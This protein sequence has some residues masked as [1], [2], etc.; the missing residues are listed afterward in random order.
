MEIC[1]DYQIVKL[2]IQ[3]KI[4]AMKELLF[5]FKSSNASSTYFGEDDKKIFVVYHYDK[6]D[7]RR[8]MIGSMW[9][10]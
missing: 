3:V 2:K 10:K 1:N 8:L 7:L 6:V 5:H 4:K 9:I